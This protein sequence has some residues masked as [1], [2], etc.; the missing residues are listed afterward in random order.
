[1]ERTSNTVEIQACCSLVT[2]AEAPHI[3][4]LMQDAV[5]VALNTTLVYM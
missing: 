1:M 3:R 4:Q 5:A 2:S